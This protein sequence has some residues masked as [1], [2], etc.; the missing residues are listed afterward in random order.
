MTIHRPLS[1]VVGACFL[2]ACTIPVAQHAAVVVPTFEVRHSANK[3]AATYARLGKYHHDHGDLDLARAAYLQSIALDGRQLGSRN[4]LAAIDV[5]QGRL[6][7]ASRLL[8]GVVRDFPALAYPVSNLGYVHYL[9]GHFETAVT[10]LERAVALDSAG[11]LARNNLSMVRAVVASHTELAKINASTADQ[12]MGG[13]PAPVVRPEVARNVI[14][15]LPTVLRA[16]VTSAPVSATQAPQSQPFLNAVTRSRFDV[17]QTAAN[18]LELKVRTPMPLAPVL[19]SPPAEQ[20]VSVQPPV[21]SGVSIE[22]A[23]GNGVRGLA[24][25]LRVAL[26]GQGIAVARLSN[27]RPY[28]EQVTRIQ[29]RAGHEIQAAL[30]RDALHDKHVV[31][32]ATQWTGATNIRLVLGKDAASRLGGN[33]AIASKNEATLH[34][35]A[36]G[37]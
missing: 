5:Q 28:T 27:I 19:Q 31:L 10:M 37:V 29:Y 22:I 9:Q 17:V 24:G 34:G 2:Q 20:V 4:A 35:A 25:R 13:G 15:L 11:K 12:S 8:E 26:H 30:L 14:A 21:S 33:R 16:A 6:D 3:D 1:M 32:D 23:N 7:E 36:A 18:V